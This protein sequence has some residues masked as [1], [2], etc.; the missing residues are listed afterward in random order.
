V[1]ISLTIL[2]SFLVL[3][4]YSKTQAAQTYTYELIP[5]QSVILY[6]TD[7]ET[8]LHDIYSYVAG[9][10]GFTIHDDGSVFTNIFDVAFQGTPFDRQSNDVFDAPFQPG[11]QLSDYLSVDFVN[12]VGLAQRSLPI[13]PASTSFRNVYVGPQVAGD[14]LQMFMGLNY[15]HTYSLT[16]KTSLEIR[17]DARE[18]IGGKFRLTPIIESMPPDENGIWIPLGIVVPNLTLVPEPASLMLTTGIMAGFACRPD[19]RKLSRC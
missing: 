14:D 13:D 9:R 18:G 5:N 7:P 6:R 16:A 12:S 10:I 8:D 1:K 3:A 17:A 4:T 11:D 15:F 19:R 2:I